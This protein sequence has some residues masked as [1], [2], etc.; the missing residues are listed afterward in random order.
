MWAVMWPYC[1]NNTILYFMSSS[2]HISYYYD[3]W[4]LA[5]YIDNVAKAYYTIPQ[6]LLNNIKCGEGTFV[7]CIIGFYFQNH[8]KEVM[9]KRSVNETRFR[10]QNWSKSIF[11]VEWDNFRGRCLDT[12]FEGGQWPLQFLYPFTQLSRFSPWPNRSN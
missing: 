6:N 10:E 2:C 1:G 7:W 11:Y 3:M 9:T 5:S 12:S 4:Q 8:L